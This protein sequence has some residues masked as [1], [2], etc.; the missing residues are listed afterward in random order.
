MQIN[1]II[2]RLLAKDS[3]QL[4]RL[5]SDAFNALEDFVYL[6]GVDQDILTYLYANQAGLS[7]LNKDIDV[8]GKTFEEVLQEDKANFLK[9]YYLRA[10]KYKKIVTFEDEMQL[11]NGK[12]IHRETV[13]TPI[14]DQEEIYIIAVVRDITEKNIKLQEL[15]RSK[16]LLEKNEQRLSSLLEHNE[17][18]VFMVDLKGVFLE[19]NP[20]TEKITGYK[21]NE[22]I[23]M[24]F[25]KIL[26]SKECEQAWG[27]LRQAIKGETIRY[28]IFIYHKDGS[29]VHLNVKNIPITVEGEIVGVYGI[30]RDIT[31]EKTALDELYRV[32]KQLESF[33]QDSA[34]SISITTL[35]GEVEFI[36]NAYTKIYGYTEEDVLGKENPIIPDWLMDEKN[37]MYKQVARGKKL[38]GVHVKRQKKSG[39]LLDISMTL[40]PLYDECGNVFAVSSIG[41]DITEDKKLELEMVKMKEELELVWNY[42]TDGICMIGFEGSILQANPAFEEMFGWN[43]MD[44]SEI[45]L[46]STYPKHQQHHIEELLIGLR[47]KDELLQFETKRKRKDG[48]L[49]DV[50]ATYRPIKKG[51]ILAIVTYKNV[52]EEKRMLL[53]L[54]ESEE[55][56]RKVLESSPEGL[57]IY[58]DGLITYINQAGL[59]F[60]KARNSSQ[61]IGKRF[62][63][64]VQRC[65][66]KQI[67]EEMVNSEYQGIKSELVEE[68]F[69]TLEGDEVFAETASAFITEEGKTSVIVMLRD[70]T[71]KRR[72]EKALR[73]TEER[74][75]IIAEHSKDIIKIV[76][77]TGNITYGSPSLEAVLGFPIRSVIGKTFLSFIHHDDMEE[78]QA[79][80]GKVKETKQV[81][82]IEIRHVH[83]DGHSIWLH[84]H[85]SPVFTSNGELEK[86]IVISSDITEAKRKE[87]KLA[88]MAYYDY[89]TGLPNRRLF[90]ARLNQAMLTSDRTGNITALLI[91]DCDKFKKINDTLGHDIGDAVIKEFARRIR[92][93]LRKKDTVSRIGGDEFAIV[94]PEITHENEIIDVAKRILAVIRE[95]MFLQG[96]Q[97]KA[98]AS[99]GIALYPTNSS[100]EDQL[101]KQAD[102]NLYKVKE[103][104]GNSFSMLLSE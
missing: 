68:K 70:V 57:M 74:F 88:E 24:N 40:F 25:S 51:K 29:E 8:I 94:L 43:Q 33:L 19:V 46:S 53:N 92:S 89:L 69:I 72:A 101:Y 78:A 103:R 37:Q 84:S 30:A 16:L 32:K 20:A 39:E 23:G 17:D 90:T 82:D 28:E 22:L 41:R 1:K 58:T 26:P 65:N 50:Q 52:T 9:R 77:P 62:I 63:D 36:N 66:R 97:I 12:I 34:D 35:D 38:H 104:G 11:K 2:K 80:L 96:H 6:V 14:I 86:I 102:I 59:E 55:R 15:Q 85:F 95:D 81:Y 79:I 100:F 3:S 27:Y 56:Y 4:I 76:N 31:K 67:E 61:V 5:V 42:T 7:V 44:K 18:A 99:I 13:L 10:A 91:I 71:I 54:K 98:T 75:R 93:S 48:T 83:Q 45:A 73:E 49:I 64:F 60:L 21:N 87:E 47:E